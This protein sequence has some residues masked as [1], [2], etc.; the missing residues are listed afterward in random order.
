MLSAYAWSFAFCGLLTLAANLLGLAGARQW[1]FPRIE[2]PMGLLTTSFLLLAI[3]MLPFIFRRRPH[4]DA[5]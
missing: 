5:S 3:G 4:S 2:H 1:I